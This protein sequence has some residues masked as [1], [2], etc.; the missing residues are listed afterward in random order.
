M[1]Y[2]VAVL[3]RLMPH[4]EFAEWC[5]VFD[6]EPF[7][8]AR[9]HDLPAA[10]QITARLNTRL[11]EGAE[12]FQPAQFMPFHKHEEPEKEDVDIDKQVFAL[13]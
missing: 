1:G 5:W 12:P 11:K 8:D 4:G 9:C 13:L 6:R 7:D 3:K 10:M 2:P